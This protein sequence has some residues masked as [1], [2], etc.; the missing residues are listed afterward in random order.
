[1]LKYIYT[2]LIGYTKYNLCFLFYNKV[3]YSAINTCHQ[4]FLFDI[5]L[6]LI[7]HIRKSIKRCFK[8]VQSTQLHI[9]YTY[10]RPKY[11]LY[12]FIFKW[13]I[14][15]RIKVYFVKAM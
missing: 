8:S 15:K 2:I 14:S 11:T 3:I 9:H 7:V 12:L 1:M 13:N 4:R 10:S 6:Y 5:I